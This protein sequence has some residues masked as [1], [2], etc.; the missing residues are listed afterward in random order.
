[1]VLLTLLIQMMIIFQKTTETFP[2]LKTNS[3]VFWK[4]KGLSI[5]INFTANIQFGR[6]GYRCG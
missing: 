5:F 1:M 3:T 2:N 4:I 6:E